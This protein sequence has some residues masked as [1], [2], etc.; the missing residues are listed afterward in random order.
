MVFDDEAGAQYLYG[1]V[2]RMESNIV[3]SQEAYA[4]ADMAPVQHITALLIAHGH[5]PE[6]A[7]EIVRFAQRSWSKNA[8]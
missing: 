6:E 8:N 1:D 4:E 2:E 7:T 5:S 3:V